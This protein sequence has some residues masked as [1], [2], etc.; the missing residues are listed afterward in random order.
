MPVVVD[1]ILSS[2]R[3][4]LWDT[5]HELLLLRTWISL[6]FST[7][8][9]DGGREGW[10]MAGWAHDGLGKRSYDTPQTLLFI[11]LFFVTISLVQFP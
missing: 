7:C 3:G 9:T 4:Q 11:F 5:F 10:Y 2:Q 8:I 6:T 1:D